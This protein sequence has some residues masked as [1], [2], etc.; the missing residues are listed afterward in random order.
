MFG[1]DPRARLEKPPLEEIM[2]WL[3][4]LGPTTGMATIIGSGSVMVRG[5]GEHGGGGHLCVADFAYVRTK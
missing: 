5:R 2:R 1:T 3:Q 4:G